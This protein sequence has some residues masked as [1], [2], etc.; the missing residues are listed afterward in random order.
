MRTLI[1]ISAVAT[2]AALALVALGTSPAQAQAYP[3]RPIRIVVPFPA[4][5]GTDVVDRGGRQPGDR[6]DVVEEAEEAGAHR[7]GTV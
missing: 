4:G 3:G 1:R 5:G 7:G 2:A 6:R